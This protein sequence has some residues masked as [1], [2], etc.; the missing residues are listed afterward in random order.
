MTDPLIGQKLGNF[1]LDRLLGQGGMAQVYKGWDVKLSRPVAIKV[2][3]AR[4]RDRQDY[5]ERFVREARTIATWRHEHIIRVYYADEQD[6]LYY[7]VMEYVKGLNLGQVMAQY[8]EA[9]ELMPHPDVLRIGR[10][11]AEA[12]DYAHERGVIHRDVK[13]ANVMVA[14]DGRVVL[15][16]FGLVL[17]VEQ[18]T[19]GEVFGSPHYIAPEQ[20]ISSA[21]AV[22][23]S[24][25]Y[26]LGVILYE[27]VTGQ[28]PFDAENALDVALLH[29]TERP[30][31]PRELH[32]EISPELEAVILKAMAPSP[33][34]RFTTGKELAEA[35][36]RALT[37]EPDIPAAPAE[38]AAPPTPKRD[39]LAYAYAFW[40]APRPHE[41]QARPAVEEPAVAATG[42]APTGAPPPTAA[43][44]RPPPP[45]KDEGATPREEPFFDPAASTLPPPW[46]GQAEA[47]A[48]PAAPTGPPGRRRFLLYAGIA[49][50]AI[51][52]AAVALGAVA[53]FRGLGPTPTPTPTPTTPTPPLVIPTT[54]TQTASPSPQ[55]TPTKEA[56]PPP[57]QQP[58]RPPPPTRTPSATPTPIPLPT[59]PTVTIPPGDQVLPPSYELYVHTNKESLFL[60]NRSEEVFPLA[61]LH[62]ENKRGQGVDG[63]DWGIPHLRKDQCV[64]VWASEGNRKPPKDL[65]CDLVGRELIG[66][67]GEGGDPFW[68]EDL[69]L[70]FQDRKL[71]SCKK[72]DKVCK[73][74]SR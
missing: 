58:T 26:A 62:L 71:G 67:S 54:G 1:R 19:L 40:E 14:D 20:A 51:V 44:G 47:E 9:G 33:E 27:I 32:P 68:K 12:L 48:E 25:L 28:V 16:D 60:V 74:A 17:N 55:A 49:G 34:E 6:G 61:P 8:V 59:Q 50:A 30:P 69:D 4:Y 65:T 22:P 41:D 63:A 42:P 39:P 2:I 15:T 43:T 23:Q 36:E 18:G 52:L 10:A 70:Y 46:F 64:V 31:P 7:Y 57:S 37:T 73:I 56:T 38:R 45:T 13:P 53:L 11:I 29:L 66:E 5:A 72:R 35:L 3:D 24:D 21:D